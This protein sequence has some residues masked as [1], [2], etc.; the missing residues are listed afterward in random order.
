MEANIIKNSNSSINLV[1]VSGGPGLSSLSFK[2]LLELSERFNLHFLDPMGT[3]SKLN[4]EPTYSNLLKEI[5]EYINDIP[6]VVLCGH[7]FG[8][9]QAIDITSDKKPNIVG[10]IVIGSPVTANAFRVMNQNF[11]LDLSQ[12]HIDISKKLEISPTDE[13]YKEWFYAYRD[14]YFNPETSSDGIKVI[15]DDRVCVKSYSLA[16]TESSTKEHCLESLKALNIPK[17]FITGELDQVLPPHSAKHEAETGGFDLE[18]I[19]SAG[20][21]AHYEC[22]NETI[23]TII[24]FLSKEG[25]TK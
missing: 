15:T 4:I 22:P 14:F 7:S 2:P 19:K 1:F 11:D 25:V 24:N 5:E 6:N 18:I 20:H 9:I 12:K 8:G 21:F 10:L 16:I 13:I 17:L 3:T 23:Q